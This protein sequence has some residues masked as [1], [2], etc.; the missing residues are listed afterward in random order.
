MSDEQPAVP[1]H[2]RE[3]PRAREQRSARRGQDTSSSKP[4]RLA[5]GAM[6]IQMEDDDDAEKHTLPEPER[7]TDLNRVAA[8]KQKI[9]SS[10]DD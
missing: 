3:S 1:G 7:P 9:A 8:W 2:A 6:S 10:L 5:L 4:H